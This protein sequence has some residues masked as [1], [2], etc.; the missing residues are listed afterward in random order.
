MGLSIAQNVLKSWHQVCGVI[1]DRIGQILENIHVFLFE[2][3]L[4]TLCFAVILPEGK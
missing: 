2:S 1:S 3:H 4:Q